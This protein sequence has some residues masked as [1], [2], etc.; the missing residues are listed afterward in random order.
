MEEHHG[1]EVWHNGVIVKWHLGVEGGDDAEGWQ[2]LEVFGAFKDVLQV[3][4]LG[5]DSEVVEDGIT[6]VVLEF[7]WFAFFAERLLNGIQVFITGGALL[8]SK[9]TVSIGKDILQ[10]TST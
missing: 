1:G 8:L 5:S 3:G 10:T 9:P 7:S 4:L 2:N 6:F